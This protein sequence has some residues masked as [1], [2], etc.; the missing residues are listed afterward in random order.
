M[1]HALLSF[2][3]VL[4][5]GACGSPAPPHVDLSPRA[6]QLYDSALDLWFERDTRLQRISQR[7]RSRGV[8]MCPGSTTTILGLVVARSEDIPEQYREPAARRFGSDKRI[9]VVA[10]LPKLPAERAG[11]VPGD[12]LISIGA[13]AVDEK[14]D[15]YQPDFM[16]AGALTVRLD[17]DGVELQREVEHLGGCK[18]PAVLTR[19]DRFSVSSRQN[20]WTAFGPA[21]SRIEL[22]T[23]APVVVSYGVMRAVNRDEQIAFL[24]AH[25]MAHGIMMY[26]KSRTDRGQHVEIEADRLGVRLAGMA[27]YQLMGEDFGQSEADQQHDSSPERE[28]AFLRAIEETNTR[29]ANGESLMLEESR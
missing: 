22:A 14:S 17:R 24:L 20:V 2:V 11:I 25:E 19:S 21:S 29:L 5:L 6:Q 13:E 12:I 8:E 15:V 7:L 16:L 4:G 9:H 18:Y 28:R 23:K 27:G 3:L 26:G 10:V 1:R